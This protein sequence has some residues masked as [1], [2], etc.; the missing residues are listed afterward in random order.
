MFFSLRLLLV[1]PPSSPVPIRCIRVPYLII[2]TYLCSRT[3][4]GRVIQAQRPGCIQNRDGCD[5]VR[6]PILFNDQFSKLCSNVPNNN[7]RPC[8]DHTVIRFSETKSSGPIDPNGNAASAPMKYY[9]YDLYSGGCGYQ[10]MGFTWVL[11]TEPACVW[12]I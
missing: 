8:E 10:L 3:R 1:P 7:V 5:I 4:R 6:A 9:W 12:H 11:C 2:C